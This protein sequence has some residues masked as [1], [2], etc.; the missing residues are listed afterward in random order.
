VQDAGDI[1]MSNPKVFWIDGVEY[2]SIAA[3][4]KELSVRPNSISNILWKLKKNGFDMSHFEI[5]RKIVWTIDPHPGSTPPAQPKTPSEPRPNL[6]A[7]RG[8][9]DTLRG[10]LNTLKEEVRRLRMGLDES[11]REARKLRLVL[12]TIRRAFA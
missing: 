4:A 3:A 6:L 9:I 12:D 2:Y 11:E 8:A 7:P 1:G 5:K 10:D